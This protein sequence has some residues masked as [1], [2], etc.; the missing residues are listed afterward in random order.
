MDLIKVTQHTSTF[1]GIT[2]IIKD[3]EGNDMEVWF[4][5]D[6]QPL[7]G[8]A[9]WENFQV[10]INRAIESCKSQNINDDDHFREVTKMVTLGSGA[11]RN[12]PDF[13]LTRFA[14]YLIAQNG[15]PKKEEVAFAQ[16]YFAVQTRKAELIA[17]HINH[18][19]R[20]EARDRL[21]ASEKQ[22]SQNIYERG[23]DD[24]GFGRI[25]SKGDRVLFGGFTTEM[26][27]RRLGVKSELLPT[28]YQLLPLPP[29]TLLPK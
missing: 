21:R 12:I 5:R 1:N 18:I 23:V 15:D 27:K 2:Q 13:M 8:Y 22:L 4:A 24:K 9:R 28:I 29:R 25:R 3:D 17:E 19:A 6:L 10:A 20:I 16:G 14:C 11:K 26:M 7:L